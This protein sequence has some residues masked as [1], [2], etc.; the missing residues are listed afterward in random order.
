MSDEL[1][2]SLRLWQPT[3]V[4]SAVLRRSQFRSRLLDPRFRLAFDRTDNLRRLTALRAPVIKRRV[5]GMCA[6]LLSFFPLSSSTLSFSF[7]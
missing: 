4:M 7:P 6:L 5:G 2:G 1:A 3:N